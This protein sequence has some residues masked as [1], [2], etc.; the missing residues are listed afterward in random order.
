MN[1]II[2]NWQEK[3]SLSYQRLINFFSHFFLSIPFLLSTCSLFIFSCQKPID[4]GTPEITYAQSKDYDDSSTVSV[5]VPKG[6]SFSLWA[7]G[8][9]LSN[10][11]AISID[12]QGVAYISE[13]SRRKSSDI[14]IRAHR[15]WMVEE[16][17]LSTLEETRDFHYK[18]LAPELSDQNTWQEDFNQDGIHDWKDL[19]VQSEYI[20]KVYDS[21]GDGIADASHL[22]ADGFNSMLTGVGAGVLHQDGRVYLTAAPDLW[23]LKDEDGDGDADHRTS[24]SH[25]YGIHIA[26]AGHDMS[27]LTMGP[28]GKIYWSIGDIGV[29]VVDK[30]GKRW[31]YPHEGAIMRIN[32]DG[33]DFEVF[34]HGLRNPQEIAFDEY[35]N[36]ISVD[37]DGDH[38]GEHERFVHILEGS[39][40]GWRTHWQFGKYDEPHEDYKVW[41]DEKLYVP[42]FS[43]QAAY[44]LPPIALAPD[45]PS[46]LVYNPGTALGKP[47]KNFFFASSFRASSAKSK[48]YAF[49]LEPKGASFELAEEHDIVR[50]IV[51]TGLSF[52]PEGALYVNDWLDGYQKKAVGRIWQLNYKDP[53]M[54]DLKAET[55]K[56]LNEGMELKSSEELQQLLSHPDMRVRMEAQ[57]QLV[58]VQ[59]GSTLLTVAKKGQ[60]ELGRI[61]GI[62]GMGQLA[63]KKEKFAS[64][65]LPLLDDPNDQVRAQTAKV[66]GDAKY[67]KA[68]SE[69]LK[70]LTDSF[71]PA[72]YFAVEALGKIQA[73]AAFDPLISLLDTL[74]EAD[75]HLRHGIVYALS[76]LNTEKELIALHKHPSTYV[77]IG[78]VVA[79]RHIKSEGVAKFLQDTDPLV[80][81]EAARAIHDDETIPGAM[82]ALAETINRIEIKNEAFLRRAINANLILG[83]PESAQRLSDFAVNEKAPDS[84]R[85]DAMWALGYWPAPP[86]LDRVEGK[87]K[88]LPSRNTQDAYAAISPI[89]ES[90]LSSRKPIIRESAAALAGRLVYKPVQEKLFAMLKNNREPEEVRI[91]ALDALVALQGENLIPALNVALESNRQELRQSAQSW[92]GKLDLPAVTVVAML[93][94]V[95]AR[96]SFEEKQTALES[97]STL[98][99]PEASGVLEKWMERLANGR[100]QKEL[101][102][103]VFNAV[104]NSNFTNIKAQLAAYE[105]KKDSL[106][107]AQYQES[108]FGGNIKKGERIFYRSNS[109]QCIRCHVVDGQG[110]KVGPDLTNIGRVLTREK[111]LE[112]LVDP[113]ARLA[114]GYGTVTLTLKNGENITGILEEERSSYIRLIDS[115][116]DSK[117]IIRNDIQKLTLIPSAMPTMDGVLS[118][119]D[120]RNIVAYLTTLR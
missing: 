109:A 78:A 96:G 88:D 49:R 70:L 18:K 81:V 100:L 47:W 44:L 13:T 90:L 83:T 51:P 4:N 2:F 74:G 64:A 89:I 26:Y 36:L 41:M 79:L 52:G 43:G 46:G 118:R 120:I 27:G 91:S 8:S 53:S 80:V 68:E 50:G 28:D 39:D 34:A 98:S 87:Y 116:G 15:D 25:G 108:L 59:E 19:E 77:R 1:H 99:G 54:A 32:P 110:G 16:L 62:W 101:R 22:Y 105:E 73:K 117:K 58:K 66:L 114:P 24:L 94:K 86:V 61:H 102:L 48:V 23:Q 63:R 30:N 7:P 20:R 69:L 93:E 97:I 67:K 6:F 55:K 33:T 29:N 38:A 84:M 31:V 76:K 82:E 104:Q 113:S 40:S 21:N 12:N 14:D 17:S 5:V 112:A 45:G 65:L 37:N 103:D 42:H 106:P 3:S 71:Q 115:K 11:V 60:T 85:Q 9:L 57:F 111:L 56:L 107:S 72:R 95:L 10:A 119:D 92:T 75:P 35:G